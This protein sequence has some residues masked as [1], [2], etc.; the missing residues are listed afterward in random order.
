[1]GPF[2]AVEHASQAFLDVT[3]E[4][5]VRYWVDCRVHCIQ[6]LQNVN[7]GILRIRLLVGQLIEYSPTFD[8]KIV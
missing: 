2:A 4:E 8:L 3:F 1:M 6:Q 7:K 5:G